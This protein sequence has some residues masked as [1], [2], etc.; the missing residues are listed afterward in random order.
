M[1]TIKIANLCVIM[2]KPITDVTLKTEFGSKK[3]S[4]ETIFLTGLD[5]GGN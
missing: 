5:N 1:T 2:I 4:G 3:Q